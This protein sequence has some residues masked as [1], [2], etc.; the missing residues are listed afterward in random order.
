MPAYLASSSVTRKKSFITLIP[1][2]TCTCTG[3]SA[4]CAESWPCPS[5]A[6]TS[7]SSPAG[8]RAA[9]RRTGSGSSSEAGGECSSGREYIVNDVDAT[10]SSS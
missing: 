9:F 3:T 1:G 8:R 7:W 6:R 10:K 5:S 4:S 2:S